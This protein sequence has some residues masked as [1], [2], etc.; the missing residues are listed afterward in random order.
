MRQCFGLMHPRR[1]R[2]GYKFIRYVNLLYY[3]DDLVALVSTFNVF[4]SVEGFSC[5]ICN[6][7][8]PLESVD[9]E[10][11]AVFCRNLVYLSCAC[12][13]GHNHLLAVGVGNSPC[14]RILCLVLFTVSD[15]VG[16]ACLVNSLGCTSFDSYG[17]ELL[18]SNCCCRNLC[19][20]RNVNCSVD[21]CTCLL[22]TTVNSNLTILESV[23]CDRRIRI[24]RDGLLQTVLLVL[25]N[26]SVEADGGQTC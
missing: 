10:V 13:L 18:R 12:S 4:Y 23:C 8:C 1:L 15:S 2:D 25:K 11:V 24:C 5:W 19:C 16:N 7:T 6:F 26:N 22:F 9:V 17:V 20:C 21:I 3:L 14:C